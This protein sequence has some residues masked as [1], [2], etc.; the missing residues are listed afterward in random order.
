V[1]WADFSQEVIATS[2]TESAYLTVGFFDQV[3][4]EREVA[5]VL[6]GLPEPAQ[7]FVPAMRDQ[8]RGVLAT[9]SG[10]D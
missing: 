6:K 10:K 9:L 3:G 5:A 7:A 1:A 2:P 4:S 8:A